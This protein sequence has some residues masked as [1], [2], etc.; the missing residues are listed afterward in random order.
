MK[1][2][3]NKSQDDYNINVLF[4]QSCVPVSNY[5]ALIHKGL[6]HKAYTSV[7]CTINMLQ[8]MSC[9]INMLQLYGL[10]YKHGTVVWP[11]L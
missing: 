1:S 5:I 9:T 4:G 10:Y 3:C 8:L 6:I 2:N 11:V 7:D